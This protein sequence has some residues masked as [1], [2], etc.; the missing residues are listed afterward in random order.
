MELD[1]EYIEENTYKHYFSPGGKSFQDNCEGRRGT[2]KKKSPEGVS[3]AP[4]KR[5]NLKGHETYTFGAKE[6]CRGNVTSKN[7]LVSRTRSRQQGTRP[8]L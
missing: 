8:A 1:E 7:Q 3:V 5:V 4:T 2:G 6:N